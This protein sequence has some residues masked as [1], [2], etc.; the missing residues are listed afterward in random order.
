[1]EPVAKLSD[2][3]KSMILS[4]FAGAASA[5][6]P[7]AEYIL[8]GVGLGGGAAKWLKRAILPARGVLQLAPL[9]KKNK[10]MAK[11][12]CG[13]GNNSNRRG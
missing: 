10:R 9:L 7:A 2:P 4:Q 8:R 1:M 6:C 5:P 13:S 11:T 3:G 12:N